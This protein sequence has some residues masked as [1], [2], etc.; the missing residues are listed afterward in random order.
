[1]NKTTA[2][3]YLSAINAAKKKNL[4]SEV[5]SRQ[6]GIYP[7]IINEVLS[8]FEPLIMM[9][10]SYNLRDLVPAIERYLDEIE[11]KNAANKKSRIIVKHNA[12]EQY[13]SIADFVYQ[14]LTIGGLV[15]R[16][17]ELSTLDLKILKKLVSEELT[18]RRK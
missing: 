5:L 6:M 15:D 9:D 17:K 11:E 10:T 3:K 7:E 4:T 16:S 12:L 2:K 18:K 13:N 1:M 14:K 8:F